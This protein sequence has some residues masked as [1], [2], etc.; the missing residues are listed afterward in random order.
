MK[1]MLHSLKWRLSQSGPEQRFQDREITKCL[2]AKDFLY[3]LL[4]YVMLTTVET[5]CWLNWLHAWNRHFYV[6]GLHFRDPCQLQKG[7]AFME[8]ESS[9]TSVLY[10]AS[11][12]QI[13]FFSLPGSNSIKEIFYSH[14]LCNLIF[15]V[16]QLLTA[17]WSSLGVSHCEYRGRKL[18][19][20][21]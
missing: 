2:S 11:S 9:A 13:T 20:N 12:Q 4:K 8:L 17:E 18:S 16:S 1:L 5:T 19:T 3:R 6:P 15:P 10:I 7:T 14:R 21:Y